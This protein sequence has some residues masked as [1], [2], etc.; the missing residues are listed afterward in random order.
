MSE[1]IYVWLRDKQTVTS[2][3]GL[4]YEIDRFREAADEIDKWREVA[5][6]LASVLRRHGL[7]TR[8]VGQAL[9]HYEQARSRR[10][11]A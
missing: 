1:D 5:D 9:T 6:H 10:P 7:L 4:T 2:G 11:H 3:S 8:E